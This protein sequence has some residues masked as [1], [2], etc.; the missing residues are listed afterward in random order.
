[1]AGALA[2]VL[3]LPITASFNNDSE[4]TSMES[5]QLSYQ[6]SERQKKDVPQQP[7]FI[8]CACLL[9]LYI[10]IYIYYAA[11]VVEVLKMSLRFE[12]M[13]SQRVALADA[14]CKVYV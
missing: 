6:G 2:S 4:V 14:C 7:T 1:M 9:A 10:Y 8:L 13:I 3:Y 11:C 12:Q 5:I